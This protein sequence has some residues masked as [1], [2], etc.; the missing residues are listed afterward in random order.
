[1]AKSVAKLLSDKKNGVGA[2]AP[3]PFLMYDTPSPASHQA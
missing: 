2:S 1:M 3:T